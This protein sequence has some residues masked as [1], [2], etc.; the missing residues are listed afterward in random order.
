MTD[1]ARL[2]KVIDFTLSL[3][4]LDE[5]GSETADRYWDQS[6]WCRKV[7]QAGSIAVYRTDV[8]VAEQGLLNAQGHPCKTAMCVAGNAI[9]MFGETGTRFICG[10]KVEIPSMPGRFVSARTYAAGLL[11]IGTDEADLLFEGRNTAENIR[12]IAAA[13]IADSEA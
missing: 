9:A 12:E 2:Q 8:T 6:T 1:I 10:G 13:I 3:P 7:T 4:Q 5:E 11:G